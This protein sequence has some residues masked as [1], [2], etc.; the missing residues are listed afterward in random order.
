[1]RREDFPILLKNLGLNT[2]G[3]E[4]GV[5]TG[6]FST[7]LISAGFNLFFSIDNWSSSVFDT[8][9]K[10]GKPS[11]KPAEHN[12]DLA[13]ERLSIFGERSKVLRM[14]SQ[15]ASEMFRNHYFDFV[16]IDADHR[17]EAVRQDLMLWYS[18]VRPG[19]IIAGHDYRDGTVDWESGLRSYYGVKQAVDEFFNDKKLEI[20]TTDEPDWKS[21]YV[22]KPYEHA[23]P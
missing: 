15:E 22:H 6:V 2:R 19:G 11:S 20:K 9:D 14:S 17:Y 8:L 12:Y 13:K 4:V 1:M 3:A 10:E 23:N 21:W 5:D 18:K 7:V 16:Y